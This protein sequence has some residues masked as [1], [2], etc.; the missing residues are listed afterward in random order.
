VDAIRR[1]SNRVQGTTD[2]I[3]GHG[4]LSMLI[5]HRCRDIRGGS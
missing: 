2:L 4:Q 1:S 3:H 5:C